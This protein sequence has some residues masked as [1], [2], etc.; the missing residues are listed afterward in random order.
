MDPMHE[1]LLVF[2]SALREVAG[3]VSARNSSSM[4]TASPASA[5]FMPNGDKGGDM[6][7]KNGTPHGQQYQIPPLPAFRSTGMA[8]PC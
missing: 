8:L 7:A 2:W 3:E 1:S 6:S 5:A 4:L